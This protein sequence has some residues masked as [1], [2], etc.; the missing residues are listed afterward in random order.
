MCC[1]WRISVLIVCGVG[2][3]FAMLLIGIV[4]PK[5]EKGVGYKVQK[6]SEIYVSMVDNE[7]K[8]SLREKLRVS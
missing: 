6:E 7:E 8:T 5:A 1:R 4:E 3:V 2:V